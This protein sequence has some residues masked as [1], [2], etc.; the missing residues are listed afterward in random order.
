MIP[1][2][3]RVSND[4]SLGWVIAQVRAAGVQTTKDGAS[5]PLSF[6]SAWIELYE[7][8]DGKWLRVGNVSNFT[9]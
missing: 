9:P 5:R 3:V 1:P 6:E 8:R 7:R 4:N 2:V